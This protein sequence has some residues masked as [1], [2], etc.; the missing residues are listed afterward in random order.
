MAREKNEEIAWYYT[1]SKRFHAAKMAAA[2]DI[3][4]N[5]PNAMFDRKTLEKKAR[6]YL[7]DPAFRIINRDPKLLDSICG[8]NVILLSKEVSRLKERC[9]EIAVRNGPF[10]KAFDELKDMKLPETAGISKSVEE[11]KRKKLD[12]NVRHKM[13]V[14]NSIIE[15]QDQYRDEKSGPRADAVNESMK[16]LAEFVSGSSAEIYLNQQLKKV[17]EA[18][19]L[20]PRDKGYLEKDDVI[21]EE[22]ALDNEPDRQM[23]AGEELFI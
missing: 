14:V 16:M 13:A 12:K 23:T 15:F 11:Y 7:T 6:K 18:R 19:G 4:R 5:D 22:P 3:I 21:A 2:S 9:L 10:S 1:L 8:G 17:N 20:K